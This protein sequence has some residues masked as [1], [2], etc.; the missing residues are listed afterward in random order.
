MGKY[1]SVLLVMR[2]PYKRDNSHMTSGDETREVVEGESGGN[3]QE[4]LKHIGCT[5]MCVVQKSL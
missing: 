3:A 5:S 2:D 1:I 4:V